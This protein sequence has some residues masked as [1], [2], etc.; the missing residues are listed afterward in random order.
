MFE[1]SLPFYVIALFCSR[2]SNLPL[3][4]GDAM[5]WFKVLNKIII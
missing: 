4:L 2:K 1:L 5:R 3:E